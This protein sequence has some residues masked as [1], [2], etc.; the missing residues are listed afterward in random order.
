MSEN[1]AN[2]KVLI[3]DD[4]QGI[5]DFTRACL[6][7]L[8][9]H[10]LT[11]PNCHEAR[12]ILQAHD[13]IAIVVCDHALPDGEGVEFLKELITNYPLAI[14]ILIT[15]LPDPT[16]PLNAINKGEIYRFIAKPFQP[17]EF[18][19]D[20]RQA[21]ERYNL[22]EENRRLESE[23]ALQNEELQQKN[24]EL[25]RLISLE[26]K[27]ITG[28][29]EE[30]VNWRKACQK[31]VDLCLELSQRIDEAL[32]KHSQRVAK[33]SLILAKELGKDQD[34]MDKL[35]IAA[36]LHDIG[37]LGAPLHLKSRQR[38]LELM[39]DAH[40]ID[41]ITNHPNAAVSMIKFL[42]EPEVVKAILQHHEYMDGT[43]YPNRLGG[44][45]I[46]PIVQVLSVA[47][48]YDEIHGSREYALSQIE[49]NSGALFNPEIVSCLARLIREEKFSAIGERAALIHE[50]APGMKLVNSI[51]NH[52]GILLVQSGQVLTSAIIHKLQ[53]HNMANRI[54]QTIYVET[55]R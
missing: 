7:K 23:I 36:L 10:V 44:A 1:R 25:E 35:E 50:L 45:Q 27:Q 54:M 29:K 49:L 3:V 48:S 53:Q 37:L 14:R 16:I 6:E 46:L 42:P 17:Q 51:Y 34:F 21:L 9:V 4:E 38:H 11:A 13:D 41:L 52:D 24:Q 30:T 55:R 15:G 8:P 20:V 12:R 33:L 19:A 47:D 2:N 39:Q 18:T 32:F 22:L 31:L 43:G 5:L 28:L 40:E 26:Q